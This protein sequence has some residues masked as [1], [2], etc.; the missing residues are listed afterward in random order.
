MAPQKP[1]AMLAC[2]LGDMFTLESGNLLIHKT[3]H[4][5]CPN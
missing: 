5:E 4:I 1:A 3:L 2:M